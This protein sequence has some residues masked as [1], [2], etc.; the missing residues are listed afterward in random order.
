[1]SI[2]SDN[3]RQRL[4]NTMLMSRFNGANIDEVEHLKSSIVDILTTPKGS[5]FHRRNYGSNLFLRLGRTVTDRL[6][7][8]LIVDTAE[9]LR[10][11]EPRLKV[12]RTIVRLDDWS[13]G[14]M[15]IDLHG[16]YFLAGKPIRLENL[17]LDF[18][19]QS[20]L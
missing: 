20:S 5:R 1:M 9:A 2:V 8:D 15:S 3:E 6:F 18:Y 12:T 13:Q 16:F 11:W 17:M 19:K 14:R 7:L 4:V 10:M